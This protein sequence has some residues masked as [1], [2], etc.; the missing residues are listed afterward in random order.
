[1]PLS[2]KGEA[3][4]SV[5]SATKGRRRTKERTNVA[6]TRMMPEEFPPG[7]F[8]GESAKSGPVEK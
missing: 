6:V 7:D 4:A 8:E 2:A 5:P 1:M 3:K